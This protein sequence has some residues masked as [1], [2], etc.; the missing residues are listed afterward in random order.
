MAKKMSVSFKETS[1][2]MKLYA[3]VNAMEDKSSWIKDAMRKALL[4]EEN[5]NKEVRS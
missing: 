5:K 2:D 4:E 1:K 3:S